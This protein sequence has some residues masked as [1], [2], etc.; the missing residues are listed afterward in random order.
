M[1]ITDKAKNPGFLPACLSAETAAIPLSPSYR[2]FQVILTGD[3]ASAHE[4]AGLSAH[5][6][7]YPDVPAFDY[8]MQLG[9][10]Q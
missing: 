2:R 3:T 6:A 9:R 8:L 5:G 4:K 1:Q 10:S 7:D